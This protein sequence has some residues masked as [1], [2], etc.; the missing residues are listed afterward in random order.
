[1]IKKRYEKPSVG[2]ERYVPNMNVSACTQTAYSITC[3]IGGQ[4]VTVFTTDMTGCTYGSGT[5]STGSYYFVN[6]NGTYYLIWY[7][8]SS[9]ES[10]NSTQ[11]SN[12]LTIM[13]N[14]GLTSGTS[15]ED[16][17]GWHYGTYEGT[18]TYGTSG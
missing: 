9:S 5:E 6:V 4:T 1:M 10:P 12:L 7:T 2:V 13:Q 16:I 14:A 18:P 8:S 15:T 17:K 11:L 3:L